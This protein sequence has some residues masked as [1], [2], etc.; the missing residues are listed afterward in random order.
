MKI[1]RAIDVGYGNTKFTVTVTDG[2]TGPDIQCR[3]ARR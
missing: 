3:M 2:T 1:A